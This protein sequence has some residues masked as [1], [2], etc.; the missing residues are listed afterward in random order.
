MITPSN[1]N[2]R[3]HENT[4][5]FTNNSYVKYVECPQ[6]YF[7]IFQAYRVSGEIYTT[8]LITNYAF[9]IFFIQKDH[10]PEGVAKTIKQI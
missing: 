5:K 7:L 8:T 10:F 9:N 3:Q 4:N 1:R 2:T 6:I